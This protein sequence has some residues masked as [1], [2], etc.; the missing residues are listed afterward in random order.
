MLLDAKGQPVE[1]EPIRAQE[2]DA[3]ERRIAEFVSLPPL[4]A[5]WRAPVPLTEPSRWE[6]FRLWL[7]RRV[8]RLLRI[9]PEDI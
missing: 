2:Q 8:V 9:D 5:S 4:P 7:A 6:R 1:I 3:F